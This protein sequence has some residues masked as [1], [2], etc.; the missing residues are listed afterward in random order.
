MSAAP[1]F[2]RPPERTVPVHGGQVQLFC[3][4]ADAD[5]LIRSFGEEWTKFHRFS[6]ADLRTAGEE[7]FDLWPAELD[8]ATTRLLDLGCGSGRWTRY[9]AH[10]VAHADAVDPSG[11]V[12][13]AAQANADLPQVRWS[14][15]RGEELPFADGSFD[16]TLCVGVLHHVRDPRR[17]LAEALRTLRAGGCFYFY[18]YYAMEQRGRL[19]RWLHRASELM[20]RPIHRLPG[21]MKRPLCDVLAVLIYLPLVLLARMTK[22]LGVPWWRRLPLAYYHNKSFRL[23][24]NDALDRFGTAYEKRSTQAE[25]TML[26]HGAGFDE[27]RFSPQPPYWHGTARK[28][29]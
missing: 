6:E 15:A 26:L 18:L 11:A 1:P 2:H 22:A 21:A 9:L 28:P 19:Y 16:I 14:Q 23:M 25:I 7:L 27:V 12:F 5:P 3:A 10:R 13:H 20:R 17:V 29:A 24:R 4:E 8:P